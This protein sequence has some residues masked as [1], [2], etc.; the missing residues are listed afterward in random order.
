MEE[1]NKESNNEKSI[2]IEGYDDKKSE[3]KTKSNQ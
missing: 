3:G 2:E 1:D